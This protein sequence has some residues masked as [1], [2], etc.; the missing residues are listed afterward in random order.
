MLGGAHQFVKQRAVSVLADHINRALNKDSL[1]SP[2]TIHSSGPCSAF[3]ASQSW[4]DDGHGRAFLKQLSERRASDR[5]VKLL[6]FVN[7]G[8]DRDPTFVEWCD[9]HTIRRW[10]DALGH[11]RVLREL[12]VGYFKPLPMRYRVTGETVGWYQPKKRDVIMEMATQ[13]DPQND[14]RPVVDESS[15]SRIRELEKDTEFL[16]MGGRSTDGGVTKS[17]RV[18]QD[19][20]EGTDDLNVWQQAVGGLGAENHV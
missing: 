4:V 12:P 2:L 18:I 19:I 1:P 7:E 15:Y 8:F 10:V 3:T 20:K 14:S 13:I 5:E 16:E 9:H 6:T 11:V 17:I